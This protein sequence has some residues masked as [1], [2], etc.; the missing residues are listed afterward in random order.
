V[1]GTAIQIILDTI[2]SFII[3]TISGG[4]YLGIVGL[5]DR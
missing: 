4:G 5:D 1:E 2:A 3:A